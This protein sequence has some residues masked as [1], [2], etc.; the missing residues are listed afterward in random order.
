MQTEYRYYIIY[1]PFQVLCQFS[2]SE[3]KKTL[4]DLNFHF[5]KTV[6]P[7]GRLDFDSE[8]LLII[9]DDPKLNRALLSPLNAH[10]R[11]YFAQVENIPTKDEISDL[12]SGPTINV[13]GKLYKCKSL[14]AKIIDEPNLPERVPGIRY[15]ANIPTAWVKLELIEGKNRQVRKMTAAINHPTLRLVRYSIEQI[16][17]DNMKSGEVTELPRRKIYSLLELKF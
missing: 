8:G 7:V 1:K 2:P 11:V 13:D 15:R 16:N 6:Y 17:I 14:K 9:S 5:P 10:K 3:N 4:S 12:Q